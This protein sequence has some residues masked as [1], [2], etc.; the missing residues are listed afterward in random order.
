[1]K[2]PLMMI[3]LVMASMPAVAAPAPQPGSSPIL[4]QWRLDTGSMTTPADT[5][6]ASVTAEFVDDGTGVWNTTYVITAKDGTARRMMSRERL[7]GAPVPITGDRMEADTVAMTSPQPGVLVM[8]LGNGGNLASVR[9]YTV[10]ADGREMI[11]SATVVGADGKPAVK[12]FR[13]VR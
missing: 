10:S 3:A 6:P 8:G 7:D 2:T 9:V 13:W 5:R 12:R 4:G 11:E 1:M